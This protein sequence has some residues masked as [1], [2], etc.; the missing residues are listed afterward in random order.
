MLNTKILKCLF[1]VIIDDTEFEISQ[2]FEYVNYLKVQ[3][4]RLKQIDQFHEKMLKQKSEKKREYFHEGMRVLFDMGETD[5]N[6][7]EILKQYEDAL[8]AKKE[9]INQL[10][11]E[12][13]NI[14]HL[15]V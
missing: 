12:E 8:V 14:K 2:A 15:K 5:E 10:F 13:K 6:Y 1:K 4:E 9:K 3:I 7:K 11:E